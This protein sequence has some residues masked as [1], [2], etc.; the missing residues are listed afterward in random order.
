MSTAT[1]I[2][3]S[4]SKSAL[5]AAMQRMFHDLRDFVRVYARTEEEQKTLPDL[6]VV[7]ASGIEEGPDGIVMDAVKSCPDM[8]AEALPSECCVV[9]RAMLRKMVSVAEADVLEAYGAAMV[10]DAAARFRYAKRP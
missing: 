1:L 7:W 8:W 2:A 5:R 9:P 4:E 10:N 3:Q 6:D